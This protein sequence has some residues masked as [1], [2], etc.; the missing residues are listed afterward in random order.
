M[1]D[2]VDFFLL[3]NLLPL[4]SWVTL[5]VA[6]AGVFCFV[7]FFISSFTFLRFQPSLSM[8]I[9][10]HLYNDDVHVSICRLNFSCLLNTSF[11]YPVGIWNLK[12][13]PCSPHVLSS[14]CL[15]H[16]ITGNSFFQVFRK[17]KPGRLLQCSFYHT[18]HLLLHKILLHPSKITHPE[19]FCVQ[20]PA[21]SF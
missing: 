12:L 9:P 21:E 2:L 1:F 18:L 20:E 7:L 3:S 13:T 10:Y 5:Q 17:I 11:R 4:T 14:Q 19:S 8:L 6:P 15:V 16:D